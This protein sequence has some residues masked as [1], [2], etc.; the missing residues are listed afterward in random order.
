MAESATKLTI[1]ALSENTPLQ[2]L[3]WLGERNIVYFL[4]VQKDGFH[5]VYIYNFVCG[6]LFFN[7]K[8]ICDNEI[9]YCSICIPTGKV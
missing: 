2:L 6:G 9:D 8:G 3:V 1:K 5:L 7:W 4:S